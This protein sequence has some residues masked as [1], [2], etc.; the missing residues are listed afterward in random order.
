M[1][2]YRENSPHTDQDPS[3]CKDSNKA[4]IEAAVNPTG[5]YVV[6]QHPYSRRKRVSGT[7]KATDQSGLYCRE[8]RQPN[9]SIISRN[10][11]KP[12]LTTEESP[13]SDYSSSGR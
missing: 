3:H 9:K 11:I 5:S 1:T 12:M 6:I 8:A 7:P 13:Y 4:E 2:N 10:A